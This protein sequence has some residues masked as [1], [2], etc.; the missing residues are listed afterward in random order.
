MRLTNEIQTLFKPGNGIAALVG[1]VVLPWIDILYGAERREVLFFFC[2]IIG[3][4]W[5]TGVCASKREKTYSSDYG[6]RKG[7]PRTLFIFLLPIIANFFDAALKT[8]GFLFYGVIFAL[9]YHTWISVT[10]NTVRAGWGQFVP[11]SVMR[12]IGSELKAKSERS[13]K[14]KEGK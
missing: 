13:Q 11:T 1:A 7:I 8:P 10:A 14:H 3:A 9:S 12:I 5:L 2:L 4:D 6:I